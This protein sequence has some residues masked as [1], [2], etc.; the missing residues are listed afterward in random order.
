MAT[1]HSHEDDDSEYEYKDLLVQKVRNVKT[2]VHNYDEN[3]ANNE[4]HIIVVKT[5][6][7]TD[8]GNNNNT[9]SDDDYD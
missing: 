6:K 4:K 5:R 2:V 1:I 3:E 7:M 8:F 9:D